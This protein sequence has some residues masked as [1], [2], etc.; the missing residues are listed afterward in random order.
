MPIAKERFLS[1]DVFR[2]LTIFLMITVNSPGAGADPFHILTHA[3]WFG[4]TI[5]DLVF[6][7]FLFAVGNAMSF[8]MKK[9]ESEQSFL[10]KVLK[11]TLLIFL[12]GYLMYWFPFFHVADDGSW[13]LNAIGNTRIMGVLQRI[14]LC[15]GLGAL[16]IRYL[17]QQQIILVA[18]VLLLGY[19]ALLYIFGESGQELTKMGNAG[20][21]LDRALLGDSHLYHGDGGD[22]FDPEGILSTLPAIVN[23]L[24][25]YL[26]GA[27]IQRKGKTYET[28]AK[29]MIVGALVLTTALTWG[30]AFPIGKKLW[31]S[32][33]VL[34]TVGLDL[35]VISC[36][37]YI[38]EIRNIRFGMRFFTILGKNPLFIYL[39]SEVLIITLS[40]IRVTSEYNAWEWF[41][42]VIFQNVAP[43]AVGSL[44][45]ALAFTMICWLA[46]YW[47]DKKRIY[48]KI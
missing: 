25:G 48:I 8:S 6:P 34:Y 13:A 33:F 19:W 26:A 7:S 37:I 36:L 22:P 31:T 45:G 39:L 2:G 47:L 10:R 28:I 12:I 32:S 27:F 17:S 5:T 41:G 15:Y 35:M 43:G 23:V 18:A 44:L 46:G 24:G 29:L 40:M 9:L 20:T 14:A 16:I 3:Q 4:F 11:R 38:V 21:L 42:I 30:M 1:L